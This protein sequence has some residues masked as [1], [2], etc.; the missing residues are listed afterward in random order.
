[1]MTAFYDDNLPG[2]GTFH[3]VYKIEHGLNRMIT[4]QVALSMQT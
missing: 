4:V 2:G 1:M 3:K